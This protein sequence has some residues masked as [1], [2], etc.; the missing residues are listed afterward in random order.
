MSVELGKNLIA[1]LG[2]GNRGP[3][4]AVRAPKFT[5]QTA[6]T[7]ARKALGNP[8]QPETRIAGLKGDNLYYFA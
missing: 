1:L 2:T 5:A 8:N 6:Y 7:D 3:V 4:E